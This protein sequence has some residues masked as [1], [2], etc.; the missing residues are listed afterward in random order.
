MLLKYKLKGLKSSLIWHCVLIVF[1]IGMCSI[2]CKKF[3]QIQPPQTEIA[4]STVYSNSVSAAAVMSGI[5]SNM[6]GNENG[7]SSGNYSISYLQGLAA[8][9]LT[10]YYNGAPNVQFYENS[11][12]SSTGSSSNYYYW[13][14]LYNE[15]HVANAVLEGLATYTGVKP[16]IKQQLNGEALFMRAF[17]HFYAVNLYGNVP[18]VTTTDYLTNNSIKP[19]PKAVVFQ[20]II[21]DLKNAQADLP[22]NFVDGAGVATQERVRPNQGAATALLARAYLFNGQWDSAEAQATAVIN[23]GTLYNLNS[24]DSVFLTNSTEA[25]WQFEAPTGYNTYDAIYFVLTSPPGSN[26]SLVSISPY[27]LNAFEQG[28]KRLTNWVGIYTADSINY[29]YYPFKYKVIDNGD[30][31]IPVTEYTMVLRLAEQYLIRAEARAQQGTN[32]AGAV[33]D[34]NVI[35]NRAGLANYSGATDQQSVLT[36]ILHERQVE[37][38]TEWGHRWFDLIRTGNINSVMGAPGNV[39]QA[40][41]G[42]WN[43]DWAFLPIP[44]SELQLNTNL[45]QNPGY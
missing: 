5:Y 29:Y 39:C 43:A 20:Q 16:S 1:I 45:I 8:D 17:L 26:Y 41:G 6:I 10:N 24:L 2:S 27:L 12:S 19:S 28:D 32:M 37:L 33:A 7:L 15:I 31:T 11:L 23:N 38:F 4:A 9:E 18:L 44:L 40:K 42:V 3:V 22:A 14:E 35:R 30:P 25:I 13:T 34:L 36:V 21:Q